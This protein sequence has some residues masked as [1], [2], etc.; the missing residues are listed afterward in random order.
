MRERRARS[1]A[2][3]LARRGTGVRFDHT[4]HVPE[5]EIC[6][7]VFDAPSSRDAALAAQIAELG[8]LR[9]VEAISSG[10][11]QLMQTNLWSRWKVPLGLGLAGL[12]VAVA[13]AL[14]PAIASAEEAAAHDHSAHATANAGLQDE[15][16]QVRR[17][18]ARY[19]RLEEAIAA[20]YELGWVNG[21]N[22]RIISGCVS[23]VANPAAGAMGYHYF[24]A[25]LVADNAVD[26]LE[27]EV[28]VYESK[29]N[30]DRKLVAVEWVVRGPNTNPPGVTTAPS[31][32]GMPM[33]IL[34]P[35]VGFYLKHAWIWKTN[36][37]GMF[38]DWNP[39]VTCP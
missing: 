22:V 38:A 24:N 33:H 27:P 20:G 4:I 23:N 16:A 3:E 8:P 14:I 1:A 28:L 13:V 35:A 5:D 21:S 7:F 31:L 39:E 12:L 15:L 26:P 36:P 10:K 30:G 32:L 37:A 34:V 6:F 17:V 18:T 2:E 19:H 29:P 9:V 25:A 11:E